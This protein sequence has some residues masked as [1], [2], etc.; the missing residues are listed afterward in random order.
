[1]AWAL[2]RERPLEG[3]VSGYRLA[4]EEV[5]A[6]TVRKH[7]SPER[8]LFPLAF[9][10]RHFIEVALKDIIAVGRLLDGEEWTFRR[11]TGSRTCGGSR[12]PTLSLGASE[13]S[14]E[15]PIVEEQIVELEDVDPW[16]SGFR[17]PIDK[18]GEL[19]LPT[20]P[21]QLYVDLDQLQD[22]M[23]SLASFLDAVRTEQS[24]TTRRGQDAAMSHDSAID[25]LEPAEREAL[26]FFEYRGLVVRR[27]PAPTSEHR[28]SRSTATATDTSL[29]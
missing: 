27:F 24:V 7:L 8:M 29:R 20:A 14:P 16:A 18:K 5:F 4:A 19:N 6:A 22:A 11:G 28:S 21:S 12:V 25:D 1:M 17:Y 23:V 26:T 9:L 10:W 13:H 3:Y 2:D 15:L